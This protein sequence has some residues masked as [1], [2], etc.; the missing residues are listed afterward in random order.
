VQLFASVAGKRKRVR[1]SSLPSAESRSC[2]QT[3][4]AHATLKGVRRSQ[5]AS[6]NR[7]RPQNAAVVFRVTRAFASLGAPENARDRLEQRSCALKFVAR[8]DARDRESGD[9]INNRCNFVGC[10]SDFVPERLRRRVQFEASRN[11]GAHALECPSG[12]L[13]D[14]ASVKRG[15]RVFREARILAQSWQSLQDLDRSSEVLCRWCEQPIER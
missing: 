10:H 7:V 12:A 2:D 8:L 9:A 13:S 14:L 11:D 4:R 15:G 6:G 3:G 1:R 5:C